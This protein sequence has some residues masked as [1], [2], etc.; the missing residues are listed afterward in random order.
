MQAI[1]I[2]KERL[3]LKQE[4]IAW[5]LANVGPGGTRLPD[6]T[7]QGDY[8]GVDQ[9]NSGTFFF[10]VVPEDGTLFSLRWL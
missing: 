7:Q 6:Y 10:F 8:W 5:C 3:H 4:M 2:P 1:K 9:Y